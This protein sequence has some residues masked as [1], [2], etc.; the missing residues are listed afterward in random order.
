MRKSFKVL[1]YII[2]S[3]LFVGLCNV[4]PIRAASNGKAGTGTLSGLWANVYVG[5]LTY[6]PFL[7][8]RK[9]TT[10]LI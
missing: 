7:D 8:G 2:G 3:L 5:S 1:T 6:E 9:A 4:D 10:P